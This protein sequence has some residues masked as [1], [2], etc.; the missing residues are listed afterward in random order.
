MPNE[1]INIQAQP[2]SEAMANVIKRRT[3]AN[4]SDALNSPA[5]KGFSQPSSNLRCLIE[6]LAAK[7]IWLQVRRRNL[8]AISIHVVLSEQLDTRWKNRQVMFFYF[9]KS[10]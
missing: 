6:E 9:A 2:E 4:K 8:A 5:I 10:R 1:E 3:R 7:R